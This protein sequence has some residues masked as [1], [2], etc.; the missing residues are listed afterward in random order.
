MPICKGARLKIKR[1]NK[2]IAELETCIDSLK[3]RLVVTAHVDTNSGCEYIKCGFAGTEESEVLEDL[4]AIIGDAVHNLKCALD[5]VWFETVRRLIPSSNWER[6]KFPAYPTSKHLE[7]ALR[8]LQIDVCAPY[9]FKFVIGQI[10]PYDGGDWAIW[11][12]HKLD[13]RDKH[14]LLIPVIHYSSIGSIYVEDQHG[15]THRGDTWGTAQLPYYVNFEQGLHIKDP[16]GVS[17]NVMFQKGD[18]GTET[19]AVD[20]LRYYCAHLLMIVKLFEEFTESWGS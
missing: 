11:P 8:N 6:A 18:A 7:L 12:V 19:R 13:I 17:S 10:K 14:W 2:H 16:G 4:S 9:F 5:H 1:A 15:E 20:T 3:E